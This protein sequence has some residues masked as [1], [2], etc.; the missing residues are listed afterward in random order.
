MR[1]ERVQVSMRLLQQ[2]QQAQAASWRRGDAMTL[3]GSLLRPEPAR[4]FGGFDYRRYLRLHHTH[5]LM[6]AKG[7]EQAQVEPAAL[8]FGV[9]QLLRWND[10]LRL[11]LDGRMNSIFPERQAGMMKAMLI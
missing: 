1:G 7:T 2:E 3:Q 9:V 6:T 10:E 4:N 11:A 5:W 8:R